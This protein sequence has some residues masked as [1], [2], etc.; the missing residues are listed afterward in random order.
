MSANFA[1]RRDI[2]S[3]ECLGPSNLAMIALAQASVIV[4]SFF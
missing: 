1:L 2:Y 3:D 4:S